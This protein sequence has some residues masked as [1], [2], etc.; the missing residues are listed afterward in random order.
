[1]F[2]YTYHFYNQTDIYFLM[3]TFILWGNSG[4]SLWPYKKDYSSM[5]NWSLTAKLNLAEAIR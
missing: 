3:K 1:M 4:I 5:R 2:S